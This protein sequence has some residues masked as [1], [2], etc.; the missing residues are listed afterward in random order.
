MFYKVVQ[1]N[2]GGYFVTDKD[3]C[4]RL[5]I[6]ADSK[7]EAIKKAEELGCYWNGVRKG[8]DCPCCGD[9][10]RECSEIDYDKLY[11]WYNTQLKDIEELAQFIANRYGGWTIPDAR[12]F[13]KNGKV[14]E[15]F[16]L[17]V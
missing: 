2:S 11:D 1:N 17:E 6:E 12:I 15:I 13:Y 10:W 4:H 9:R 5:Y 16:K 8:I 3:L 7:E 14:T